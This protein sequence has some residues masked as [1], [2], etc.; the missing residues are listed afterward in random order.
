MS[1][2]YSGHKDQA[3]GHISYSQHG[4]DYMILNIF[5]LLGI[6]RPSYLDIGAHDPEAI[7]NTKLLYDRGSRGVNVEANPN[8]IKRF[9]ELRPGDIN[10]NVGVGVG[11]SPGVAEFYMYSDTSGRNTFSADEVKTLEGV[12]QV[13]SIIKLPIVTLNQIVEQ[14]CAGVFPELL[15]MDIEGYDYAVLAAADFSKSKPIVIVVETRRTETNSM[16]AML[17]EKEFH[18]YCRMGENLFFIHRNYFSRAY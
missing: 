10:T 18:L 4:D 8:L 11:V 1:T 5:K 7:S 15:T 6:D 17:R 12:M 2:Y 3:F 16:A 14:H 13:R 9:N